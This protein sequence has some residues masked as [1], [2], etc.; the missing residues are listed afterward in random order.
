MHTG[1]MEAVPARS[2]RQDCGLSLSNL[3]HLAGD[4]RK[5]L[6]AYAILAVPN[7]WTSP[8]FGRGVKYHSAASALRERS[9]Q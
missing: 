9:P 5:T 8:T 2:L 6:T 1:G 7:F 4:V 3:R